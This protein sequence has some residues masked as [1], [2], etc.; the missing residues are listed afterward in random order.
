MEAV[1]IKPV[2]LPRR[3]VLG[4]GA[5]QGQD[6]DFLVLALIRGLSFA[7]LS[8]LVK[9]DFS[10]N[11]VASGRSSVSPR[12]STDALLATTYRHSPFGSVGRNRG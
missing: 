12:N 6:M 10:A 3:R 8:E 9:R 4:G 11:H 2:F 7:A 1:A 5:Q